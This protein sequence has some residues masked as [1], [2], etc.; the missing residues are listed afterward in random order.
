MPNKDGVVRQI[1]EV[2]DIADLIGDYLPLKKTGKNYRTN[3]PFHKDDTPSFF[4]SPELSLFHCFGCG[5][6]GDIITFVMEYEKV[7]FVE[8][9]RMLADKAGIEIGGF[10]DENKIL[11]SIHDFATDFYHKYLLKTPKVLEYLKKRGI[12]KETIEEFKLGFAPAGSEFLKE[13]K[14]KFKI[15]DLIKSGL[16][17]EKGG[18]LL[19][20]FFLRLLFPLFSSGGQVIGF[21]GRQLSKRGPKY[22][23]SPDTPI[24]KKGK[25][26]YSIW[27]TKQEIRAK[28]SVILVEGY[29]DFISLYQSGIKNSVAALGTALTNNQAELLSRY[30][31]DVIIFFDADAAGRAATLRSLGMLLN[32]GVNVRIGNTGSRKDPDEIIL[33]E[34][35]EEFLN[36]I[37][38]SKDFVDHT[39]DQIK[40]EFDISSPLDLSKA[41]ERVLTILNQINDPVKK[42]IFKGIISKKL[43]IKEGLLNVESQRK[44]STRIDKTPDISYRDRCEMSLLYAFIQEPERMNDVFSI[45]LEED[46]SNAYLRKVFRLLK[47]GEKIELEDIID[48]LSEKQMEYIMKE[49][50]KPE[51]SA[52]SSAIELKKYLLD[53]LIVQKRRKLQ[54]VE[55]DGEEGEEILVEIEK[56]V[57]QREQMKETVQWT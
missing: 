4:V 50:R 51:V 22:L 26:L 11:Y 31:D 47:S 20:R 5:K 28:G 9:L 38:N 29:F 17:K 36:L 10:S 27:H 8:A 18:D 6:S 33:K 12:T 34:G 52:V 19:D 44:S 24:H 3:C 25:N 41:V 35:K 48:S 14:K 42:E 43:L 39:L 53:S 55:A 30:A 46:I 32:L 23:N 45:V 2:I 16:A 37:A 13:A 49:S 40:E 1:K 7:P 54:K 15:D 57:E 21:G 56:L